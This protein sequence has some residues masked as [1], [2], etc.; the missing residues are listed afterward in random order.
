MEA[1]GS[2]IIH[3]LDA[4]DGSTAVADG[5]SPRRRVPNVRRTGIVLKPSNSRVVIRPFEP[6][7]EKRF[8]RII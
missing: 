6:T 5:P 3:E 8:E 4:T 1:N 7:D 2:T